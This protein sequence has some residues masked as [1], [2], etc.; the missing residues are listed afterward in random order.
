MTAPVSAIPLWSGFLTP[1]L[2][3]L[4]DG[5][6]WRKRDLHTAVEDHVGLTAEQRAE[7]LPSGQGRADNRISWA[8]SG[9]YRA[10]LVDKPARATFVITDAGRAL[11]EAHPGGIT[12][13]VL[14]A[15]PAYR[16]YTPLR[17][18]SSN[19]AP[20]TGTTEADEDV[21]PLEQIEHGVE[22][23][24][25]EVAADLLARLRGQDPAFLEQSVLD[26]LV[27]MGY[28]G[29][30]GRAA[31]I[32]GSGDGGVDGVI[33]QDPLGLERIYV[34]AKR[35]GADNTVG[36]P[37]I[38]AFVGALHGVGAARGVFIT[39]SAFTSGAR[40][41]AKNI[42]TRVILIDG[43]RLAELMIRYGV[44]VQTRQTFTVVEVDE[45]YF[46]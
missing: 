5:K 1:V 15:V 39:T 28:G 14:K 31:R 36:R 3:V 44:A 9:L 7:V 33:D 4:T 11:L 43:G 27:A 20:T 13:K 40:E 12:E 34:Q 6:I 19:V 25:A 35:Y 23:L 46:E 2:E 29:T 8:L 17:S 30:E 21:D 37:E 42:G 38:Q 24:H 26:V 10:K 45:D 16:D 32:G 18:G 22:R 41:Y